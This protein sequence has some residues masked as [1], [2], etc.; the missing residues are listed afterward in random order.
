MNVSQ[1]AHPLHL[2]QQTVGQHRYQQQQ[3]YQQ[4]QQQLQQQQLQQQQRRGDAASEVSSLGCG[5]CKFNPHWRPPAN[6]NQEP[7]P[8]VPPKFI[9][10]TIR[11]STSI[12]TSSSSANTNSNL[13]P[14]TACVSPAS[15]T[16]KRQQQQQQ[17]NGHAQMHTPTA[18]PT[19]HGWLAERSP[20]AIISPT[21]MLYRRS[22]S[23]NPSGTPQSRNK[24]PRL[25]RPLSQIRLA[26]SNVVTPRKDATPQPSVP[27]RLSI[28]VENSVGSLQ[29][30][31]T[32]GSDSA[33]LASD[34]FLH[35]RSKK[36]A[37]SSPIAIDGDHHHQR[38][39]KK[40]AFWKK[41]AS[42]MRSKRQTRLS[43]AKGCLA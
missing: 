24:L 33:S 25:Q 39:P 26:G 7:A 3:Y 35:S 30:A 18:S 11:V 41:V 19:S 29:T 14:A 27:Q 16:D 8:M 21:H 40:N 4:Q 23:W 34:S 5:T 38:R 9:F 6:P 28:T 10:I 22:A 1:H 20:P 31:S 17:H 13:K 43:R 32:M 12:I 37:A 15:S 36:S 42:P 2:Q